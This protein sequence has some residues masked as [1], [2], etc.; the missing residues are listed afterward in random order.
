MNLFKNSRGC[1]GT[2]GDLPCRKNQTASALSSTAKIVPCN[3]SSRS[4]A[5][6]FRISGIF[7][8]SR[9]PAAP[10]RGL[11]ATK[12]LCGSL[13]KPCGLTQ[14][15]NPRFIWFQSLDNVYPHV[16]RDQHWQ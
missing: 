7:Q 12:N 4:N 9:K 15:K 10:F 5:A 16:I 8:A 3:R 2:E 6:I 11:S 1:G 14:R 13:L